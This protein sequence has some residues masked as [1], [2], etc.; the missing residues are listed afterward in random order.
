MFFILERE[1][2]EH[3][4]PIG[5]V[6]DASIEAAA[7]KIGMKIVSSAQPPESGVAHANLEDG[8]SLMELPE[9]TSPLS[10][11]ERKSVEEDEEEE[12]Q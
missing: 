3:F 11:S 12:Q 10:V 8:F 5:I 6:V 1:V 4:N 7:A 2:S 9:V